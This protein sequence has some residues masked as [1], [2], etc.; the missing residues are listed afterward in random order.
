M[1]ESNNRKK[2]RENIMIVKGKKSYRQFSTKN[3]LKYWSHA[4][5][6]IAEINENIK[7]KM[8]V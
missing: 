2:H 3:N 1:N 4:E 8:D 6:E 5:I 7:I